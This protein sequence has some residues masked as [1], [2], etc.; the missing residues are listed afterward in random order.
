MLLLTLSILNRDFEIF[1]WTYVFTI[2]MYKNFW[3]TNIKLTS[4]QILSL[5]TVMCSAA[6]ALIFI[7]PGFVIAWGRHV[8]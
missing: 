4:I 6:I 3:R 1:N 2:I 8:V 5:K 7:F